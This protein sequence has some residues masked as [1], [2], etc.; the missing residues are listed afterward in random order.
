MV[1]DWV[2]LGFK[3]APTVLPVYAEA[4]KSAR[5][6]SQ[7]RRYTREHDVI[8][9]W[10]EERGGRPAR[11]RGAEVLRIAFGQLPPNWE[12][13]D[14]QTFFSSFDESRLAFLYEDSPDSRICKLVKGHTM[15]DG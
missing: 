7:L 12:G 15:G 6:G 3:P 4:L 1:Q 9:R 11:V 13:L 5:R 8:R 2:G 10:A 14:W